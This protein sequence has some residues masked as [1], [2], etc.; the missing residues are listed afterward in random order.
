LIKFLKN[1]KAGIKKAYDS[2][3]EWA[4]GKEFFPDNVISQKY[5]QKVL[6]EIQKRSL[7]DQVILL[8]WN[9]EDEKFKIYGISPVN[10]K[11]KIGSRLLK[12]LIKKLYIEKKILYWDDLWEDELIRNSLKKVN[13][14]TIIISPLSISKYFIDILIIIDYSEWSATNQVTNFISYVSSVLA[15]AVHNNRLYNE[16]VAKNSELREW[17]RNVEERI[18]EGAKKLVEKEAKYQALFEGANDG[19]VVHDKNGKI[20][21]ANRVACVLFGVDKSNLIGS[22]INRFVE[23]SYL[24]QHKSFFDQVL[25]G[26]KVMPLET[27]MRKEDG[28]IFHAELSSRGVQFQGRDTIQTFIRD[29]TLRKNLENSL[30]ESKEKYRSF[31]ESS[32]VGVFIMRNGLIQFVNSRFGEITGYNKD[33]L[34]DYCFYDLVVPE[35]KEVVTRREEEKERGER[36]SDHYQTRLVNKSGEEIWIEIHSRRVVLDGR[37]AILGNVIDITQRK[38]LEIQLLET[39]K[40]DSIGTLAGG[41]AHDFNNLLGGILGYASLILSEISKDHPFYNDIKAIADTTKKAAELTNRL[42]AFARGGKY[43]VTNIDINRMIRDIVVILSHTL[44]R[45]IELKTNLATDLKEVKG[46]SQQIHQAILNICLNASEAMT[47]GGVI[48][49]ETS[50]VKIKNSTDLEHLELTSG[51]YV[52]ISVSDTGIGMDEDTKSRIFEPFFTTKSTGEGSGLGMSMVYGIVKNHGGAVTVDS[53]YGKGTKITIFLPGLMRVKEKFKKETVVKKERKQ[54]GKILMV[55][56]EKIIREVGRRMLE[57]GGFEVILAEDGERAIEIYKKNKGE[58]D[59]VILDLIMPKLSGKETYNRLKS[60]DSQIRVIFTSGYRRKD[61]PELF[62]L[63]ETHFIQKPFQTELLL[64]KVK[65]LLQ[66]E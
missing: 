42:L 38:K 45:S 6:I 52:K 37:A 63:D 36:I 65:D 33:E 3:F 27:V 9:M 20:I 18:E 56:D 10:D 53:E 31:I 66:I 41:I 17:T 24:Q 48:T 34:I 2:F 32:L 46:D 11:I 7:A 25:K 49:I 30:R 21:E 51:D 23:S 4:A 64:K 8:S 55:D 5:T 35:E 1:N 47:G 15:L 22:S 61:R 44:D 57:K 60:I 39:K 54:P 29:I 14:Q 43:Q 40:L 13:L 59:L 16:L 28:S 58:I 26:E 62:Y 12:L 50:N 19:I